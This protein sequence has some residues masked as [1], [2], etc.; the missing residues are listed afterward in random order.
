MFLHIKREFSSK[1]HAKQTKIRG[2]RGKIKSFRGPYLAHGPY[3]VHH[4]YKVM[5]LETKKKRKVIS[6]ANNF[7]LIC[8]M[9]KYLLVFA[10]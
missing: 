4:C 8:F 9:S 5:K 6:I 1:K 7:S 10:Q 2:Y 3:V